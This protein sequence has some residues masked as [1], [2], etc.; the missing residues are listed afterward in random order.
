MILYDLR[1]DIVTAVYNLYA[2]AAGLTQREAPSVDVVRAALESETRRYILPAGAGNEL[3]AELWYIQD[4]NKNLIFTFAFPTD[5][6]KAQQERAEA[7]K[8]AFDQKL[9]EYLVDYYL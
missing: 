3:K 5:L 8:A 7:A 2:E 1:Q 6:T 4:P 9:Q